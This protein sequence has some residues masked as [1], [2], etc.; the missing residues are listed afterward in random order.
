ML[1]EVIVVYIDVC[2]LECQIWTR[3]CWLALYCMEVF[4]LCK[5]FPDSTY[6]KHVRVLFRMHY[7]WKVVKLFSPGDTLN[8]ASIAVLFL[9]GLITS[10]F[11]N[12]L[13]LGLSR[14][15]TYYYLLMYL[16]FRY[17][18]INVIL[19]SWFNLWPMYN[20]IRC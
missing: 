15:I 3:L 14:N 19:I 4:T 10:L 11:I 7:G 9:R 18:F 8:V 12:W 16:L 20:W 6:A 2:I 17:L 1:L 5:G 13:L